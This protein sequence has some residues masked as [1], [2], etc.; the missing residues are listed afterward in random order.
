MMEDG[1]RKMVVD[2]TPQILLQK[3]TLTNTAAQTHPMKTAVLVADDSETFRTKLATL[4]CNIH[5]VSEVI[6]AA[7]AQEILATL[8]IVRPFAALI[9]VQ[10]DDRGGGVLLCQIKKTFP[11]TILIALTRYASPKLSAIF[12]ECGADYCFDKNT[13]LESIFQ[14]VEKL[15]KHVKSNEPQ[16]ETP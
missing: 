13:E 8:P 7:S 3:D 4:V 16:K 5:G 1:G 2:M 12:R 6:Q 14:T 10:L 11:S 9:S 15:T